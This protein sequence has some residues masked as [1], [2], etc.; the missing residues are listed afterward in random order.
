MPHCTPSGYATAS[1]HHIFNM[2]LVRYTCKWPNKVMLKL[3]DLNKR[4]DANVTTSMT[5]TW[6]V[7]LKLMTICPKSQRV[8]QLNAERS[9][10]YE[11]SLSRFEKLSAVFPPEF[12]TLTCPTTSARNLV[13][14]HP[15]TFQ[16]KDII[17]TTII[18]DKFGNY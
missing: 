12:T 8:P 11:H 4:I 5:A 3:S 2:L 7:V 14:L 13:H 1:I 16:V 15:S 9:S 6:Y 10:F 18:F 17:L